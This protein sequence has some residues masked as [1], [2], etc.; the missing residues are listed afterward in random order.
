MRTF[1]LTIR[2]VRDAYR[3]IAETS[4]P[5]L[6]ASTRVDEPFVL[7]QASL[8]IIRTLGASFDAALAYGT[9]LGN[10]VFVGKVGESMQRVQSR[11]D[12]AGEV[13]HVLLAIEDADLIPLRWERLCGRLDGGWQFL[14]L[15]QRTP[16]SFYLPSEN[17]KRYPDWK[18]QGQP[19][20]SVFAG[21]IAFP[22]NVATSKCRDFSNLLPARAN[23]RNRMLA[24]RKAS[25]PIFARHDVSEYSTRR[26]V[27]GHS[28]G[29]ENVGRG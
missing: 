1:T 25:P 20:C 14:R 7:D 2:R 15:Q 29:R 19:L 21:G 8:P 13:L 3:V 22:K 17:D 27:R 24:R 11:A 23:I 26:D 9:A 10:A 12:Q 4:E 5:G 16:F 28:T 18:R 6:A